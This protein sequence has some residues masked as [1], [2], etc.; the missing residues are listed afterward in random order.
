MTLTNMDK[1]NM[2]KTHLQFNCAKTAALYN[3]HKITQSDS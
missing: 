1:S 2:L 3:M